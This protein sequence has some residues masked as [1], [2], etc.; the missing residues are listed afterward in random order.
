[1]DTSFAL[2]DNIGQAILPAY[3]KPF[4]DELLSSWLVRMSEDHG[5]NIFE[6]CQLCWPKVAIFERDIDRNVKDQVIQDI[7]VRTNCS[8]EEVKSSSLRYFEH[9][10]Y[11][12]SDKKYNSRTK[13]MLPIE[14]IGFKHKRKGL[15][16]CP[17]CLKRDK[18]IPYYRKAWRL[19]FSLT[20]VHCGCYLYD[21]CPWCG[22]PICFFRNSIGISNQVTFKNWVTCSNCKR[23]LRDGKIIDAP[24]EIVEMQKH[25]YEILEFG[26][27]S[28]VIYPIQYFDVL[29]QIV[30]LLS[31]YRSRFQPLRRDLFK[32]HKIPFFIV[33]SDRT[34]FELLEYDKRIQVITLAYWLLN[35]WP[36]RFLFYCRKHRLRSTDV[37]FGL[38]NAPFWYERIVLD[39]IYRPRNTQSQV[40]FGLYSIFG[41]SDRQSA[42][43]RRRIRL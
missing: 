6:F 33:Q 20:C 17:G 31:T 1:M 29:H 15:M 25:L 27:S 37:L 36:E 26:L 16:Y 9:K 13:W 2:Y 24:K 40:P 19:S 11:D 4:P 30:R 21:C 28:K 23:D 34:I 8:Y 42:H 38:K 12:P 14:R 35:D 5:L 3:T 22:V 7:A 41:S 39:E 43:H 10:L 32:E 18:K